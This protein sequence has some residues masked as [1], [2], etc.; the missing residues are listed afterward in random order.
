MP[1]TPTLRT[2]CFLDTNV[3]LY[4]LG[5]DA[6]KADRADA[7]LADGGVVSA[8]VLGEV[9]NVL[10]GKRWRRPWSDVRTHLD[11]IRANTV[12]L[13]VSVDTHARAVAYAERYKLQYFDALHVAS[14]VLAGCTTL[15]SEDMHDGLT[16]DGL[17]VRN[18]FR[19]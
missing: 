5:D 14:A 17:T 6:A 19:A 18:P 3:L 9:V 16:I 10:R 11:A 13:P 12:V 2:D 8:H 7:L 15:W 1:A 4:S